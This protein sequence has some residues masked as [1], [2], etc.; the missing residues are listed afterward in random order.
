MAAEKQDNKFDL[1]QTNIAKGIAIMMLLWHHLF[2]NEPGGNALYK[3]MFYINT[4]PVETV[5]SFYLKLCVAV[6]LFLSGYG[7]YKRYSIN[8]ENRN[9]GS[10]GN[11]VKSDFLMTVKR[12]LKLYSNYWI[13]Y[14]L[15]VPWGVF[16]GRNTIEIYNG[17]PIN[18]II[19]FFGLSYLFYDYNKFTVN[20]TWWFMSILI[21]CYVLFPVLCRLFKRF[22]V[23]TTIA[24]ICASWFVPDFRRIMIWLQP[25]VF[26]MLLCKYNVFEK[27]SQ[28]LKKDYLRILFGMV[29]ALFSLVVR[30][31]L[32][33]NSNRL[34]WVFAFCI[35]LF[36]YFVAAKIPVVNKALEELGKKSGLIFLFH[37]FILAYYFESIIYSFKYPVLI[38]VVLLAIC[39]AVAWAI[40]KA[41]DL[42]GYSK[43]IKRI[44]SPTQKTAV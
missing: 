13:I 35:V 36:S 9:S 42:T 33:K 1:R 39:Y 6:F 26:G 11:C 21:I 30:V 34:D 2:Y 31:L 4:F 10:F 44:T 14:L 24:I 29:L 20:G 17:K 23:I 15:F 8:Y 22:S 41:L 12:L 32:L 7:L 38:F 27:I 40:Q 37:T 28:F 25:F 43:L 19:D 3:P 18:F 5:L 16:F